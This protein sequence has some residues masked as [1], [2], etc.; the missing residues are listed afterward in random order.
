[1]KAAHWTHAV[2]LQSL[3]HFHR[4]SLEPSWSGHLAPVHL[5]HWWLWV[6]QSGQMIAYFAEMASS[7]KGPSC[8]KNIPLKSCGGHCSRNATEIFS[9]LFSTLPQ[10]CASKQSCLF[11]SAGSPFHLMARFLLWYGLLAMCGPKTLWHSSWISPSVPGHRMSP[12]SA[13]LLTSK[14]TCSWD[15]RVMHPRISVPIRGVWAEVLAQCN[16]VREGYTFSTSTAD[17]LFMWRT[18]SSIIQLLFFSPSPQYQQM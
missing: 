2:H 13:S 14:G 12:A 18:P 15:K 7:R 11:G 8:T 1:M 10:T 3:S 6:V 17:R 4:E 16:E 9:P 5:S